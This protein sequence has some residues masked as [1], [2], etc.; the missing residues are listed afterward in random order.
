MRYLKAI[1]VELSPN[2]KEYQFKANAIHNTAKIINVRARRKGFTLN[3][4]AIAEA[5][6]DAAMLKLKVNSTDVV[7]NLPLQTIEQIDKATG[8]GF[9][10]NGLKNIDWGSSMIIIQN[11]AA[12]VANTSIELVFEYEM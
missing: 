6:F 12:A 2:G 3:D 7:D 5:V 11:G 10:L 8:K 1:S 4:K 9:E